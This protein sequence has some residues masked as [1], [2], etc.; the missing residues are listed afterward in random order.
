MTVT[1]LRALACSALVLGLACTAPRDTT[2][3][4]APVTA[5]NAAADTAGGWTSLFDGTSLDAW[6]GFRQDSVPAGWQVQDGTL[7]RVGGGG[8]L[9]TREQY[10]DFEL[11]LEWRVD[12]AGNSGVMYRVTEEE[13][14]TYKTG[15]EMQ[16]LDDAGH[17]DGGAR[18]TAAGSVYGLYPAPEG[19]VR[20]AG[21]WNA[22]RIRVEDNVV[23]HWLNGTQ[24]ARY[25]L[26]SDEWKGLVAASKFSQWPSY[27]LAP[28][29]HI[30][31]QDH[32]DPV[33]F[34]GIRIRRLD[35]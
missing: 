29:G 5:D 21:E 9:I 8:D 35:G 17:Q 1:F 28:Q 14:E 30:A 34:R 4:D 15:P 25:E 20:P 10:G 27:G 13:D 7:A 11:E 19:V 6:R 26:G 24:I 31:L 16:V 33:W 32:G 2:P 22:A 12:S 18:L 23:E 3:G